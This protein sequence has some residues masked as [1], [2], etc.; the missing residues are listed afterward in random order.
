MGG[1]QGGFLWGVR[2]VFLWTGVG[3]GNGHRPPGPAEIA[4]LPAPPWKL[5]LDLRERHGVS[6]DVAWTMCNSGIGADPLPSTFVACIPV[7]GVRKQ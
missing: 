4:G 3:R 7:R 5:F 1:P 6:A 2:G